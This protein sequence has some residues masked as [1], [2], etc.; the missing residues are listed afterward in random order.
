M[1]KLIRLTEDDIREIVKEAHTLIQYNLFDEPEIKRVRKTR[2][3]K[4]TPQQKAAAKSEREEKKKREKEKEIDRKWAERGVAQ[5]DLF[6]DQNV[7]ESLHRIVSNAINESTNRIICEAIPSKRLQRYFQNHGG[8]NSSAFQDGL[9]DITDNQINYVQEYPSIKDAKSAM[10]HMKQN[11]QNSGLFFVSY[12]AKDGSGI[13]V[14]LDRNKVAT[15]YTWGGE[16]TKKTGDRLWS[17][18]WNWKDRNNHYMDDSDIYYYGGDKVRSGQRR[19]SVA[20]DFGINTNY[21]YKGRIRDLAKQ[22]QS[23]EQQPYNDAMWK[24]KFSKNPKSDI[25]AAEK[26]K[27][28]LMTQGRQNYQDWRNQETQRMKNYVRKYWPKQAKQMKYDTQ[29]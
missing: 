24:A 22:K 23:Y 16:M 1:K 13:V 20:G 5:G 6:S 4:M 27:E 25:I 21:D 18:D 3:D 11:P 17:N 12:T 10:W 26:N 9:G 14:G 7:E 29:Q 28:Q 19:P 2:K 15:T 8:V